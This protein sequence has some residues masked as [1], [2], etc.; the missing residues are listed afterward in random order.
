MYSLARRNLLN[1]AEKMTY[2]Q[3][4]ITHIP[5]AASDS[6]VL[7]SFLRAKLFDTHG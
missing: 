2:Q 1:L 6:F 5:S 3:N 7:M 4:E